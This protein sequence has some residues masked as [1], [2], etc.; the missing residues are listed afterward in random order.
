MFA[1]VDRLHKCK[2]DILLKISIDLIG[3]LCYNQIVSKKP[4]DATGRKVRVSPMQSET[5]Q[6]YIPH[7]AAGQD[8]TGMGFRCL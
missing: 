2:F 7:S 3:V 1:R 4:I 5:E 8:G 6:F